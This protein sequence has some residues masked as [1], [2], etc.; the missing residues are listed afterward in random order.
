MHRKSERA[1][2]RGRRRRIRNQTMTEKGYS[3]DIRKFNDTCTLY[4]YIIKYVS[5]PA[6]TRF[7][8]LKQ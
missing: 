1:A 4:A 2:K 3:G 7:L 5:V 8:V 6:K